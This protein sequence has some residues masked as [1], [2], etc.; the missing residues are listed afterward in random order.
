ML[1]PISCTNKPKIAT[2]LE[3]Q[4]DWEGE[5]KT[6]I[7][8][9]ENKVLHPVNEPENK[10]FLKEKLDMIANSK[11]GETLGLKESATTNDEM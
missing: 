7:F 6:S 4:P 5:R 10:G 9:K 2:R 1:P 8:F 11:V 3:N